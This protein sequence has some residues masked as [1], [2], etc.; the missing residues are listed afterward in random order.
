M[1][2]A[3]AGALGAAN[4][5]YAKA[6]QDCHAPAPARDSGA[7]GCAV[8]A[9]PYVEVVVKLRLGDWAPASYARVT[10]EAFGPRSVPCGTHITR[11]VP[12]A[13]P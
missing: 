7:L 8:P 3:L 12:H 11:S 6:V 5:S 13:A 4:E 10:P 9:V 1:A 2:V